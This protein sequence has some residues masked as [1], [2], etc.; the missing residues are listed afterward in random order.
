MI[1]TRYGGKKK[2]TDRQEG[3]EERREREKREKRER[4]RENAP[5]L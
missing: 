4:E 5:Y 3:R 1:N 2:D